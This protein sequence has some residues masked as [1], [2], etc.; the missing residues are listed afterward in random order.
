M[1][2]D[3]GAAALWV[4]ACCALLLVVSSV[5]VMRAAAVLAR[6]RAEAAADLAALAA[7]GRLG[8]AQP[9]CPWAAE[10]ARR[11]GGQ[12]Q[13]CRVQGDDAGRGGTVDV[14]VAVP[15][16]LPLIG[17][18]QV[19]AS[20]RAGRLPAHLPI[21]SPIGCRVDR[22]IGPVGAA[23][24]GPPRPGCR[25]EGGL[26]PSPVWHAASRLPRAESRALGPRG[27]R[28]ER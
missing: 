25:Q 6:H 7:A 23:R 24:S 21:H 14:V 18:A 20:A 17:S 12:L 26:P 28:K 16:R 9:P 2:R 10:L 11:N 3:G 27:R 22:A 15:V 4:L 1:R 5:G 8:T 19:R 13:T